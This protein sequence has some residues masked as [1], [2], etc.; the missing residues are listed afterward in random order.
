ARIA[1]EAGIVIGWEHYVGLD[2]TTVGMTGF[3]ASAPGPVVY[4]RFGFTKEN[5]ITQAKKLLVRQQ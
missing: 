5:V 1:I 4:E 3:G 2:G